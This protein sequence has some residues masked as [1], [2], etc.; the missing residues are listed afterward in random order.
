MRLVMV[1]DGFGHGEFT[2]RRI[3]HESANDLAHRVTEELPEYGQLIETVGGDI[4]LRLLAESLALRIQQE[5]S[6]GRRFPVERIA[7]AE[8]EVPSHFREIFRLNM[9]CVPRLG[10][11]LWIKHAPDSCRRPIP[12]PSGQATACVIIRLHGSTFAVPGEGRYR[13]ASRP[14]I[15]IVKGR[16]AAVAASAMGVSAA[17]M[18]IAFFRQ[19]LI[20]TYFGVSRGLDIYFVVYAIASMVALTFGAI[21]DSV[22]VPHLVRRRETKSAEA[23][24]VLGVWVFRWSFAFGVASAAMMMVVTPL[25]TPIVATGFAPEERSELRALAVYFVPWICLNLPYFAA[26]A[27]YKSQWRLK[28]V[29]SAEI[30][31]GIVTIISLVLWHCDNR[32]L[33]LA[34]AAG[35]AVG[36][37][38]LLP[39][40]GL[41]SIGKLSVPPATT[42]GV[43]RNVSELYLAKQTDTI[44][45]LVDRHFQSLVPAGG[46]AA[47]GYAAQLILG[48][49]SLISMRDIFVVPLSAGHGRAA[50]FERLMI[51]LLLLSV[52][53]AAAISC[54]AKEIVQILY[55]HGHFNAAATELTA[56]VLQI[57]VLTLVP[58]AVLAPL[59][60]AFQILDRINLMHFMY[61]GNAL[62]LGIFGTIFVVWLDW[63][64]SGIAWMYLASSIPN[65]LIIAGLLAHSGL[66]LNWP[67]LGGYF[68]FAVAAASAAVLAG[69]ATASLFDSVWLRLLTGGPVF[70]AVIA[71]FYSLAWTRLRH[72]VD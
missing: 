68:V 54:F 64:A 2:K 40:S 56:Q 66:N 29:F 3:G 37:L 12:R 7:D 49:S 38:W 58:S 18:W 43:L 53:L 31:L 63:S 16:F 71:L 46:I 69:S 62:I 19:I 33:P 44:P 59:G 72:V 61:L 26:A 21:F 6:T 17:S 36:L 39:G 70:A 13:S 8:N 14:H 27:R 67:R 30:V 65:F 4:D 50:R 5:H 25:L 57:Y 60:R 41:L 35:Y 9:S 10:R 15:M 48:L 11:G 20:A 47:I 42:R 22:V 52:P 34:Y 32:T 24:H 23:S 55:Q 51:G 45:G 1:V 28:R